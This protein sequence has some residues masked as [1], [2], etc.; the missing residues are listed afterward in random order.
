MFKL[1]DNVIIKDKH[2]SGT[3]IDIIETQKGLVFTVE[4]NDKGKWEDGYGGIYPLF[5]CSETEI[6][7]MIKTAQ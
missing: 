1:Y 3:I 6:E 4:S 7:R 5:D 2:I